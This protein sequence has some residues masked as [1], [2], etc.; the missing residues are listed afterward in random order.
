MFPS[1][2][3]VSALLSILTCRSNVAVAEAVEESVAASCSH[4]MD[5][6]TVKGPT[7]LL[8]TVEEASETSDEALVGEAIVDSVPAEETPVEDVLS[9]VVPAK[10]LVLVETVKSEEGEVL[11]PVGETDHVPSVQSDDKTNGETVALDQLAKNLLSL[12]N[13]TTTATKE[14]FLTQDV[15]GDQSLKIAEA[16]L[17]AQHESFVTESNAKDGFGL[18]LE[19]SLL[20]C[21]GLMGQHNDNPYLRVD[22]DVRERA[23]VASGAQTIEK[24]LSMSAFVSIVEAPSKVSRAGSRFSKASEADDEAAIDTSPSKVGL[25]FSTASKLSTGGSVA[26][27]NVAAAE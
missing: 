16:G 18:V 27:S 11:V 8:S 23:V 15:Q 13:M 1:K 14:K 9:D 12:E 4:P 17:S 19:Q 3:R 2:T 6:T 25:P 24:A 5:G 10:S 21:G 20:C 26:S 22:D 7:E